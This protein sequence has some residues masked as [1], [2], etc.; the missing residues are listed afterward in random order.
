M[1]M[2]I[3]KTATQA[4]IYSSS[5]LFSKIVSFLVLVYFA[6]EV[7]A[8]NFGVYTYIMSVVFFVQPF[9]MLGLLSEVVKRSKSET[10]EFFSK[11]ILTFLALD[12]G[13]SLVVGTVVYLRGYSLILAGLTVLTFIVVNLSNFYETAHMVNG[14]VRFTSI[15]SFI[16]RLGFSAM[17]LLLPKKTTVLFAS[18]IAARM[19]SSIFLIKN[20]DMKPVLKLTREFF[21]LPYFISG[22]FVTGAVRIPQMIYDQRFGVSDLGNF[23][24][25]FVIFN[26]LSLIISE[27][28]GFLVMRGGRFGK[29]QFGML[30]IYASLMAA[31]LLLFTL[32]LK[33]LISLFGSALFGNGYTNAGSIMAIMLMG[34]AATPLYFYPRIKLSYHSP[35]KYALSLMIFML[36]S[37][38]FAI[39]AK[40][41]V[42]ASILGVVAQYLHVAFSWVMADT[43]KPSS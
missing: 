15:A 32:L 14:R 18:L 30:K 25:A 20:L 12:L 27:A 4:G 24:A 17:I 3:P 26:G 1:E 8:S 22:I 11:S 16:D 5:K 35:K 38:Y 21:S 9:A 31:V 34:L 43:L 33:P 40:D 29:K 7:G 13:F 23:G 19:A 2:K 36:I 37:V 28:G 41:I 42:T 10:L 6:R 39:V